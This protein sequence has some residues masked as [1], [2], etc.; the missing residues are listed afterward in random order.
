MGVY[1][2]RDLEILLENSLK[3][4]TEEEKD[5]ILLTVDGGIREILNVSLSTVFLQDIS[6]NVPCLNITTQ[7]KTPPPMAA[8]HGAAEI[9]KKLSGYLSGA[10]PEHIKE[11]LRHLI[12]CVEAMAAHLIK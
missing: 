2:V 5:S 6:I 8:V 3:N 9:L 1:T 11:E 10:T 7:G 12:P 4:K